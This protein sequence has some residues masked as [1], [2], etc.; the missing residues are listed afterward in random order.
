MQLLKPAWDDIE[1]V[2]TGLLQS[3]LQQSKAFLQHQTFELYYSHG[4]PGRTLPHAE[5]VEEYRH[6]LGEIT[7]TLPQ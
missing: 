4:V 5:A 1:R 3:A 7:A 2:P 6:E